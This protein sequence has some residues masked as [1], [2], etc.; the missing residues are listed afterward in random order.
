MTTVN[1]IRQSIDRQLDRWEA[2]ARAF[3]AQLELTRE[4][5]AARVEIQQERL[6]EA[7]RRV[8]EAVERAGATAEGTRDAMKRAFEQL[9]VQMALGGMETRES[10][11]QRKQAIEDG[12]AE[13]EAQ[14]DKTVESSDAAVN[15]AVDDMKRDFVSASD[16][17]RAELDAMA[18]Q[19]SKARASAEDAWK[20][21]S[22]QMQGHIE[23]FREKLEAQRKAASDQLDT[24]QKEFMEGAEQMQKAFTNLFRT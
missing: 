19:F 13:F 20:R 5:A 7:G 1:E 12:L 9:R 6:Q 2:L 3:E 16:A 15:K 17:L 4:Q 10:Y 22:E 21:E 24:F 23:D 18:A 14:L 8:N 11:E